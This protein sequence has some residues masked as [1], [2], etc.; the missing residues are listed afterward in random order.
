MKT[1][2]QVKECIF[3][4]FSKKKKIE[5]GVEGG[6]T[7]RG[8]Q[9]KENRVEVNWGQQW[10]WPW[11]ASLIFLIRQA[12]DKARKLP[13]LCYQRV[14]VSVKSVLFPSPSLESN[15]RFKSPVSHLSSTSV[16]L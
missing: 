5:V 7:E 12:T 16:L 13:N 10:S 3:V 11:V 1:T 2:H 15:L 9:G 4:G 6:L 8:K 14:N